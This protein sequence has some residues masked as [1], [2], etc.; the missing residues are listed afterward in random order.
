L[1]LISNNFSGSKLTTYQP[2]HCVQVIN[3]FSLRQIVWENPSSSQYDDKQTPMEDGALNVSQMS[4]QAPSGKVALSLHDSYENNFL[5]GI[6]YL[7]AEY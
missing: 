6:T 4:I 7:A 5:S 1:V 3:A 2:R